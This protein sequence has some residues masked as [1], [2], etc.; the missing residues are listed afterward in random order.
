MHISTVGFGGAK[1][2]SSRLIDEQNIVNNW[3]PPSHNSCHRSSCGRCYFIPPHVHKKI[4][5]ATTDQLTELAQELHEASHRIFRENRALTAEQGHE[6]ESHNIFGFHTKT[7][8]RNKG[9]LCKSSMMPK[10]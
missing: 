7:F 2:D 5:E 4:N 1:F 10:T 6:P 9:N 8:P 3:Q